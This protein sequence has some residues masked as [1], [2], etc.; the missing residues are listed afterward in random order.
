MKIVG[1]TK[2]RNE[3]EIIKDTLDHFSKFCNAGIYVYD[4]CSTDNTKDICLEHDAVRGIIFGKHW[5]KNREEAEYKNRQAVLLEALKDKPDWIIYFDADERIDWDFKGFEN[6]DAVKMRLFD[7]YIT[8]E[9]KNLNYK[10]RKWLGPEFREIIMMFR[11]VPGINYGI[12]DQRQV[13][14]SRK[15]KR[16]LEAG[17]VKHY[18]KAISVKQWEETCDYYINNFKISDY[19]EKWKA[20]KGKAIHTLSD[21]GN[22]LVTWDKKEKTSIF[23]NNLK[24]RKKI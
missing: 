13:T 3:S 22:K 16:V 18:G 6:Y 2:V 5:D 20:R 17:F 10:D 12:P 24:K 8:E 11:N 14:L 4:D 23:I 15:N 21:F 7:Y 9:D 19:V 1:I